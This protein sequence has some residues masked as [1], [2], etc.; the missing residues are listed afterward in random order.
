MN[1]KTI[2]FLSVVF[3]VLPFTFGLLPSSALAEKI[4][5]DITSPGL[6]RLPIAVQSFTGNKE[7][8]DIVKDDLNFTGLFDCLDDSA[9]IERPD[10]PFNTA[11]WMGLGVEL[12][13]K[14]HV[15]VFAANK[16]LATV[17]AY[18]VSD[19]R[20]VMRK[21]YAGASDLVRQLA[22]SIAN[23]IYTVLTGQQGI[24]KTKIAFIQ[25]VKGKKDLL[26]MDWD[27]HRIHETGITS[28]ILMTPHWSPDK[29]KFLYSAERQR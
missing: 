20:E 1:K 26:L 23:D 12:V 16:F 6:K 7:I 14:G 22:H 13:V 27:G 18:D 28:N 29:T 3:C 15:S 24:F 25:D 5:I 8:S 21:E 10:Q 4:Y 17:S 11:S 2:I 9:Q 19:G